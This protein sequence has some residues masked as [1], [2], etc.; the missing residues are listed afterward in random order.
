MLRIV[1]NDI[2][3][4]TIAKTNKFFT[5]QKK[6]IRKEKRTELSNL[7]FMFSRVYM[8]LDTYKHYLKIFKKDNLMIEFGKYIFL[9]TNDISIYEQYVEIQLRKYKLVL[10]NDSPTENKD[11]MLSHKS[12][13]KGKILITTKSGINEIITENT[14]NE[15]INNYGYSEIII[16]ITLFSVARSLMKNFTVEKNIIPPI[17]SYFNPNDEMEYL[18]NFKN[19]INTYLK[20]CDTPPNKDDEDEVMNDVNT[21]NVI[22]I[23]DDTTNDNINLEPE[24][25]INTSINKIQN[26]SNEVIIINDEKNDIMVIN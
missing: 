10:Y 25:K 11:E 23:D 3:Y 22:K 14:S 1:Y 6:N 2:D 5:V 17:I 24:I 12:K 18:K 13:Y 9:D 26:N 8:S 4:Y 16:P 7:M 20:L 19:T 15:L 21:N